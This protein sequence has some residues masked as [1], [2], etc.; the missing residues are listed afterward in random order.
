VSGFLGPSQSV[1]APT[2]LF[3]QQKHIHAMKS[4]LNVKGA[5]ITIFSQ[6]EED[7]V[8]LTDIAQGFSD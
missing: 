5:S 8:S 4:T 7:Y 2:A 1:F 6:N 3:C